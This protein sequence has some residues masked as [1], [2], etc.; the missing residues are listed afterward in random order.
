MEKEN[1]DLKH[2]LIQI[3]EAYTEKLEEKS[4]LLKEQPDHIDVDI[5]DEQIDADI[6]MNIVM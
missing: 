4:C 3:T 1:T 6:Q 2:Q 5:P